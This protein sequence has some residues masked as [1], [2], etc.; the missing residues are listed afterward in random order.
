MRILIVSDIHGKTEKLSELLRNV[1][2]EK[3]DLVICNGDFTDMYDAPEE[4]SQLDV[5]DII[6][7]KLMSLKKPLL[8]VPG[9]HDPYEILNLLDEY[10]VNLHNT[11]KKT[12][13]TTL[14]GWGGAPT[15]FHTIFEPPE[16]ETQES[17]ERLGDEVVG[18]F[19]LVLHNPPKGTLDKIKSGEHVGSEAIRDFILK[20]QP[21]LALTAHI[22]ESPGLEKINNTQVFYPGALFE[23]LYGIVEIKGKKASCEARKLK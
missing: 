16:E 19:I 1:D 2:G 15:P 10:G 12:N 7:Q 6:I 13:K 9:N 11:I 22:H 8:C 23:G 17:L 3:L 18:D 14:L 5:A 20:K 21:I 4:F